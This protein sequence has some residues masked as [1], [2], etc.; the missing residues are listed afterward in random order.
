LLLRP[1]LPI[2]EA[3]ERA[4]GSAEREERPRA[5][6][7]EQNVRLAHW[8]GRIHRRPEMAIERGW[9]AMHESGTYVKF[10]QAGAELFA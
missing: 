6:G 5:G 2:Y 9:L 8:T 1:L 4:T 3:L 10:T 7:Y